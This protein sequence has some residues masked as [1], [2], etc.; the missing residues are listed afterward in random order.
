MRRGDIPHDISS[1]WHAG[2]DDT[3][4]HFKGPVLVAY[5][6]NLGYYRKIVSQDQLAHWIMFLSCVFADADLM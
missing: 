4:E 1:Y 5:L 2:P 3:N 6:H